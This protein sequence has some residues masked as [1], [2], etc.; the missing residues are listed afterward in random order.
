[1]MRE[2]FYDKETL[3]RVQ[4]VEQEILKDLLEAG[5]RR[6][7]QLFLICGSAI[8][9][10]RHEGPIPWDDDIDVGM[11]RK[12]YQQ[13]EKVFEEE[14]AD[15]Y[16]LVTTDTVPSYA[17]SV[18][19]VQKKGTRFISREHIDFHCDLG[20]CVD[21]FVYDRMAPTKIRRQIQSAE[22]FFFRSL[23]FVSGTPRPEFKFAGWKSKAASIVT[24]CAHYA[25]K[26]FGITPQRIYH[27]HQRVA[28]RYN[29]TRSPYVAT[30]AGMYPWENFMTKKGLF[31]L[32]KVPYADMLVPIPHDYDSYLRRM[33]GEYMTIPPVEKQVNHKP[34]VI[35]FGDRI[36]LYRS[37]S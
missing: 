13:L 15:R 23:L 10:V 36:P 7:F 35:D 28:Q 3:E 29:K 26:G 18:I 19:K 24:A 4:K 20:I 17:C 12:D 2:E 37:V 33:Y 31:P 14:F 8:G 16:E 9:A 30:Y 22:A 34:M 6:G 5:E 25:L 1:M 11:L 32:R 27:L 21:I